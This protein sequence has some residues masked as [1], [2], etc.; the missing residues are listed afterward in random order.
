MSERR[1]GKAGDTITVVIISK[2]P[3]YVLNHMAAFAHLRAH[4]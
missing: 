1:A 3:V 2:L 4:E